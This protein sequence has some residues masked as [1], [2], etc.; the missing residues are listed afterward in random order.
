M[1]TLSSFKH[2]QDFAIFTVKAW[3]NWNQAVAQ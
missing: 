2:R 1:A 3:I